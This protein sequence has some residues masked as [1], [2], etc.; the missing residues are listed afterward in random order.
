M[1]FSSASTRSMRKT[2]TSRGPSCRGWPLTPLSGRVMI[3]L[4]PSMTPWAPKPMKCRLGGPSYTLSGTR[5]RPR[6]SRMRPVGLTRKNRL[7]WTWLTAWKD[8]RLKT[9]F[10]AILMTQ[11]SRL[12]ILPIFYK[13]RTLKNSSEPLMQIIWTNQFITNLRKLGR[14]EKM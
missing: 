12:I 2:S 10:W 7:I 9:S 4:L 11:L 1:N 5:K 6:P 8:P 14:N 13:L 3:G